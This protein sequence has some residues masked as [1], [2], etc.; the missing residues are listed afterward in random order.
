MDQPMD[1][2]APISRLALWNGLFY[3]RRGRMKPPAAFA[4]LPD[5]VEAE[6]EPEPEN[7][8]AF[9]VPSPAA[10]DRASRLAPELQDW[11]GGAP[12]RQAPPGYAFEFGSGRLVPIPAI[13]TQFHTRVV[14]FKS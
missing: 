7:E 6:A 11:L 14:Q 10:P 4:A 12:A 13:P 2:L 5:E 9:A 3:E 1:E 8:P